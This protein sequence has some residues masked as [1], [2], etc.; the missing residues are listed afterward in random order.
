MRRRRPER[1]KRAASI[2]N[3]RHGMGQTEALEETAAAE[4]VELDQT[5]R[6]SDIE[7]AGGREQD[8]RERQAPLAV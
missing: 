8:P 4:P 3:S 5:H 1:G 2:R 7:G 6:R